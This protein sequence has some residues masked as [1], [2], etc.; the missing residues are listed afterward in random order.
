MLDKN[1]NNKC[2]IC[3][4][5]DCKNALC[6]EGWYVCN[7]HMKDFELYIEAR[8]KALMGGLT[9]K[10][11][12]T[13]DVQDRSVEALE[14]YLAYECERR[15]KQYTVVWSVGASKNEKARIDMEADKAFT[16]TIENKA[17][18]DIA[19][20]AHKSLMDKYGYCAVDSEGE[21]IRMVSHDTKGRK[22][23]V[24]ICTKEERNV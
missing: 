17:L 11:I 18:Q 9:E 10:W 21:R 22:I 14:K 6:I 5:H 24:T 7:R 16:H 20:F 8:R 23:E 4:K 2:V 19:V 12:E 1:I 15:L 13:V 3:G